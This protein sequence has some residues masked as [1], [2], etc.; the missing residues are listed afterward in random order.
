LEDRDQ[1]SA[2]VHGDVRAVL[3]GG[4][5]VVV[6]GVVVL[7]FDGE[8]GDA[9]VANQAGGDIVLGGKWVGGAEDHIGAAVAQAN[10]QVGGLGGD[11]QAGGDA[12]APQRVV[13]DEFLANDL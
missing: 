9:L 8:D 13:L 12:D 6:V 10:S 4:N 3:G 7:A 2:V 11:V 1:V 5:D